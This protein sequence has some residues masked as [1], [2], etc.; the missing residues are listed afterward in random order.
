MT[1]GLASLRIVLCK[2]LV[3]GLRDRRSIISA[4]A[5]LAFIPLMLLF[6]FKMVSDQAAP[7]RNVTVPV[8]GGE[9]ASAL[10]DWLGQQPGVSV[11]PGPSEPR[12]AV[13]EGDVSFAL[14]VDE[15]F[16]TLFAR[17]RTAEVTIVVDSQ[18]SRASRAADR[19]RDLVQAYGRSIA[20]QRL[21]V[22]G[23]SP[24]VIRPVQVDTIDM[25]TDRERAAALLISIP[26]A[27]LM[28]VFI[29][30][31]Q[32][33]I[34]STAGERERNTLEPLLARPV[35]RIAVV[36]GKWLASTIF[37]WASVGLTAALLVASLAY[38]P[39]ARL[40][41]R[42]DVGVSEVAVILAAALPLALLVSAVQMAVATLA[43]SY[44]EAQS[45]VSLLMLLPALPM[46]LM[47]DPAAERVAWHAAAPVIGQFAVIS[48]VLQGT[49]V[50]ALALV[51]PALV[52]LAGGA[53]ALALT[54]RLFRSEK[55]VFGR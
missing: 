6:A 10:V 20:A 41:V 24:E 42:T 45:Y 52:S 29:G 14:V 53:V 43:R 9:R 22:R 46:V 15:D 4:L 17:S 2:E 48:E 33:A 55:V 34:D 37:S 8:V 47:A 49:E 51:V 30:G 23:V 13:R 1:S 12:T 21:V 3:D 35:K 36:G 54:A 40:G 44:K 5:P 19:V 27:L 25:A 31:L 39:L 38:S 11:V 18:D 26:F 16:G 7:V 32:I 50:S 28:S